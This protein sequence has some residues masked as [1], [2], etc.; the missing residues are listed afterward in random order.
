MQ[1]ILNT[2]QINTL[3][4]RAGFDPN[5]AE[6]AQ[7]TGQTQA[8][9]VK[10]LLADAQ[11]NTALSSFPTLP[12]WTK[13]AG[14]TLADRRTTNQAQ[15]MEYRTE[16]TRKTQALRKWWLE[17]L[18]STPTPLRERMVVFWHNHFPSAQRKVVSADMIL[19]QHQILREHAFGN[20]AVLLKAAVQSPAMLEYLDASQN[21]ATAPNENL[22]R[23][24]M[25]LFTLGEGNYTEADVKEAA[26]TLTGWTVNPN[27]NVFAYNVRVHDTGSKRV[28]G[29][30][31]D[32][33]DDLDRKSVV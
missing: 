25:E 11:S 9:I 33:G 29:K 16:E 3:L 17:G 15:R 7:F 20:F 14:P 24:L 31:V 32:T 10:K 4:S 5:P 6:A 2:S 28:L 27:A 8:A 21:R 22:G 1:V 18:L 12:E 26:R 30:S 19:Q 23:E 13:T